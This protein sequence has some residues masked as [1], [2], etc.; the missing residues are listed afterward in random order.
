MLKDGCIFSYFKP[1]SLKAPSTVTGTI[2]ASTDVGVEV[3]EEIKLEENNAKTPLASP[4][5]LVTVASEVALA[6]DHEDLV[7]PTTA[8]KSES[9]DHQSE[10]NQHVTQWKEGVQLPTSDPNSED[11]VRVRKALAY[12]L[13]IPH[14]EGN[15]PSHLSHRST[16]EVRSS[17]SGEENEV[18]DA[19]PDGP[20]IEM[21][22][23][24]RSSSA[25]QST[26]QELVNA[27]HEKMPQDDERQGNAG[28]AVDG[29]AGNNEASNESGSSPGVEKV[30]PTLLWRAMSPGT[31][32]ENIPGKAAKDFGPLRSITYLTEP[33]FSWASDTPVAFTSSACTSSAG[34]VTP[35]GSAELP[36]GE[37]EEPSK[38][39]KH[40]ESALDLRNLDLNLASKGPTNVPSSNSSSYSGNLGQ[41]P[42]TESHQD[43]PMEAKMFA[44]YPQSLAKPEMP[45][46]SHN[47]EQPN[48]RASSRPVSSSDEHRH[49]KVHQLRARAEA[50]IL[51]K[52]IEQAY[53]AK[54]ARDLQEKTE[55]KAEKERADVHKMV[56]ALKESGRKPL[57]QAARTQR[58]TLMASSAAPTEQ[59]LNTPKAEVASP[60]VLN[61]ETCRTQILADDEFTVK[62][63]PTKRGKRAQAFRQSQAKKIEEQAAAKERMD[64]GEERRLAAEAAAPALSTA[65]KRRSRA[66]RNAGGKSWADVAR[67]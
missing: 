58:G 32:F 66:R 6:D 35:P 23:A 33:D 37:T 44:K 50:A 34:S 63:G 4:S 7:V 2:P 20:I 38:S 12:N 15:E 47:Q 64:V 22:Q 46:Q 49:G 56:N 41:K 19:P 17:T 39:I 43:S 25:I 5:P 60:L 28:N 45:L 9:C 16:Q 62:T 48:T 24:L 14:L 51:K 67:S 1:R 18:G 29:P 36:S 59:I 53:W 11:N 57:R 30:P 42:S 40:T 65:A 27:D 13:F 10:H 3:V 8:Q 61:V 55:V 31:T 54:R 26:F 21:S 52:Q